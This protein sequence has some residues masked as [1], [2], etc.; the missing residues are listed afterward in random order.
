MNSAVAR[1]SGSVRLPS[2]FFVA[3]L[4]SIVIVHARERTSPSRLHLR[5]FASRRLTA[6][7]VGS[8]GTFVDADGKTR[9]P[10]TPPHAST[11]EWEETRPPQRRSLG[12]FIVGLSVRAHATGYALLRF[13]DLAPLQFGVIDV[14]KT[15][16]VQQKALEIS[17]VLRDLRQVAPEKLRQ[18]APLAAWHEASASRDGRTGRDGWRWLVS[19][20]D[21]VVNRAPP[22]NASQSEVASTSAML[23]GLVV[24]E[25]K[26]LFK[27]APSLVHPR[28]SRLRLGLKTYGPA[29]GRQ[30]VFDIASRE[31]QDFPAVRHRN[32]RLTDETFLMSD[33][34]ASARYVQRA[35][36][37]QEMRNDT[38]VVEHLR[39]RILNSKR[40]RKM[41]AAATDLQ[42]RRAGFELTEVIETRVEKE[43][44][45]TLFRMVD[46]NVAKRAE[47]AADAGDL[48]NRMAQF[49]D[50]EEEEE[51]EFSEPKR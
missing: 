12:D 39:G 20:D 48:R 25:A 43:L 31:I 8:S 23:Q 14:K 22:R 40:F 44:E 32:G 41:T 9:E 4:P 45:E 26:R 10:A 13:E 6:Q 42:P 18:V 46:R 3:W 49:A 50:E 2:E 51:D 24:A 47:T 38:A 34:W 36:L 27:V 7:R 19:V 17:A 16:E 30:A 29:E 21:V 28:R 33:A 37:I 35:A 5:A 1:L 11:A 15:K